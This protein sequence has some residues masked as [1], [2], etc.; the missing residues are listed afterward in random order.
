ML[1]DYSK[2]KLLELIIKV[3]NINSDQ[4]GINYFIGVGIK[5]LFF[6]HFM[7]TIYIRSHK[8]RRTKLPCVELSD[9]ILSGSN[10]WREYSILYIP[11]IP[12]YRLIRI[13]KKFSFSF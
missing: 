4:V 5:Y 9:T 11:T 1:F 2:H 12:T 7:C 3:H 8:K 10:I 13:I 6:C